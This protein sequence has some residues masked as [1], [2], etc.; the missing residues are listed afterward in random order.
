MSNVKKAGGKVFLF[1]GIGILLFY[2]CGRL[3]QPIWMDW[4]NYNT[5]H[6]FY[7]EPQNTIETIFLGTSSVVN[8]ITPMELYENYG[9]CSYNLATEQQSMLA[10]YFWL[11]EAYRLHPETLKNVFLDVSSLRLKAIDSLN[12]KAIDGM[13][14]SSVKWNAVKAYTDSEQDMET[15]FMYFVPLFAYHDRWS[16]LTKTDFEKQGYVPESF[17]RGYH[18]T[19]STMMDTLEERET[20][21]DVPVLE[22][23]LENRETIFDFNKDQ[24][25]Y[26]FDIIEFCRQRDLRLIL[27]KTPTTDWTETSHFAV[28]NISGPENIPFLDFNFDPLYGELGITFAFDFADALHPSYFAAAK[29]T[30]W[31]GNYITQN[32]EG[33]DVR[34]RTEYAFMES[35]LEQYR[36]KIETEL[37]LS[38]ASD[39][40]DYI[41][42]VRENY[43]V[44]ITAKDEAAAAL[45]PEER[46][47]F[48]EVG[49]ELLSQ[50]EYRDSYIGVIQDGAVLC[51]QLQKDEDQ[52]LLFT[53]ADHYEEE[54]LDKMQSG[55]EDEKDEDAENDKCL[56]YSGT[57]KPGYEVSLQSGGLS[58]GNISSCK[59]DK[60]EY[61]LNSRGINLVVYNPAEEKVADVASF[62]TYT[63]TKRECYNGTTCST[64]SSESSDSIQ[65][66]SLYGQFIYYQERTEDINRAIRIHQDLKEE[67]LFEYLAAYWN[68]KD[69]VIFLSAKDE[70][71]S[72]LT[73]EARNGFK[74][75]QLEELSQLEFRDSYIAYIEGGKVQYE[76]RDHG[77]QPISVNFLDISVKSGGMDSGAISSVCIDGK[78]YSPGER[79]INVVVYSK[80][81]QSVVDTA[82]FDTYAV[83]PRTVLEGVKTD[84]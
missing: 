23:V 50:L 28:E 56:T 35:E 34:G 80:R 51:E 16:S 39:L 53:Y 11:Q 24:L 73:E 75:L 32:C 8:G 15:A 74:T 38:T 46:A 83:T 55:A 64:I 6:G 19:T 58:L 68:D 45:S 65:Q 79:G 20:I 5:T 69:K 26:F 52:S 22:T 57:L 13:S 49:L 27:M 72:S 18:L 10:S 33:T 81:A 29:M 9:L 47:Y 70:A 3:F 63:S 84:G 78:E 42:A 36:E 43:T 40:I 25:E 77:A 12:R 17:V 31:L 76:R 82:A 59:I 66:D 1:L 48:Q 61:S 71:A 67:D 2:L 41:E 21:K 44:F 7:K 54:V 37:A 62:D 60:V 4:N 30:A 14:F